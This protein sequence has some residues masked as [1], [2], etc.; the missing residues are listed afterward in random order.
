MK[1]IFTTDFTTSK[2]SMIHIYVDKYTNNLYTIIS[3]RMT[4]LGV[5][6]LKRKKIIVLTKNIFD[7]REIFCNTVQGRKVYNSFYEIVVKS[8]Y[9]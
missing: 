8:Y 3:T 9:L 6:Y 1:L 5:I 4:K 7:L 2:I